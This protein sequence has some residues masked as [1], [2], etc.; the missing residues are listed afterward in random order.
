AILRNCHGNCNGAVHAIK[1]EL[2][3]LL[4]VVN[5]LTH[6][7]MEILELTDA[8][9]AIGGSLNHVISTFKQV[10]C[11]SP[12]GRYDMDIFPTHL[13]LHG[14][15]F[16]YNVPLPTVL[17]LFLLPH[18]DQR[19]MFL[20]VSVDPPILQGRT[21][22]HFLLFLFNKKEETTQSLDLSEKD[23]K[24]KFK[25]KLEKEMSGPTYK[26]ISQIIKSLVHR[27]I[28]LPSGFIGKSNTPAL[29]CSYKATAGF[30]YPLE[31]DFIYVHKP[32]IH[33]WFAEVAGINFGRGGG[34]NRS[35]DLEVE[36]KSGVVHI[37]SGIEKEEQGK[38]LD[39]ITGKKLRVKNRGQMDQP[40]CNQ[41]DMEPDPYL[42]RIKAEAQDRQVAKKVPRREKRNNED[43]SRERKKQKKP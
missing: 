20:V 37:F 12:R 3:T 27:K 6:R 5:N 13:K 17:R 10:Q 1:V 31:K 42:E 26:V 18:K 32:T 14:K 15:T 38:L 43:E 40:H 25:G 23:L 24:E 8:S 11:L 7:N 41:K 34:S 21:S 36:I 30:L 33:I 29:S 16:N 19:Q 9:Q 22:Y 39:F 35:F 2:N 4:H 28:T